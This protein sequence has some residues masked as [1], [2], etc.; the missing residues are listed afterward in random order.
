MHRT[1]SVIAG[2]VLSLLLPLAAAGAQDVKTWENALNYMQDEKGCFSIPY[3]DAQSTCSRKQDEVNKWCKNSG[4]FNCDTVDPK[5]LQRQIETL[6][7][8]RDELTAERGNLVKAAKDAASAKQPTQEIDASIA[9]VDA[10]IAALNN[11]RA[12]LERQVLEASR[13]CNERLNIAKSCRDYRANV[14]EVFSG[15]RSRANNETDP[16]IVP[17][18]RRLIAWWDER[19]RSHEEQLSAVKRAVETCERVLNEIGRLGTF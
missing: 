2:V 10:A 1:S 18:A 6:K 17:L 8:R 7:T 12:V 19:Y 15:V 13:T 4:P 3:A 9:K 5:Q 16:K 11:S 14:Q